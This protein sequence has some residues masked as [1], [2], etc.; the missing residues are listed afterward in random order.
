[1]GSYSEGNDVCEGVQLET[2]IRC[3]VRESR[4]PAVQHVQEDCDS[5]RQG[6][7]V[8]ISSHRGD[9]GE[10]AAE[11]IAYRKKAG[12]YENGAP[13]PASPRQH[14]YF[15]KVARQFFH[16]TSPMTELPPLTLSPTFTR[17]V[18]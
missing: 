4:N 16:G 11:D 17:S 12:K 6:C 8:V 18:T 14:R 1:R 9:D 5:D 2:E 10:I 3:G 13:E 7:I 15:R